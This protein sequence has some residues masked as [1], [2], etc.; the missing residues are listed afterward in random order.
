MSFMKNGDS[1]TFI[2]WPCSSVI[3]SVRWNRL[4]DKGVGYIASALHENSTLKSLRYV[5][6]GTVYIYTL[7][8][9]VYVMQIQYDS[10]CAST[11]RQQLLLG[12][13]CSNIIRAQMAVLHYPL[14]HRIGDNSVE[15]EGWRNVCEMLKRNETLECIGSVVC[16]Q[17]RLVLDI[18][19][20]VMACMYS[21]QSE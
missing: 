6:C 10:L 2:I 18:L 5:S 4:G 17:F 21:T 1:S 3:K 8:I 19:L 20:L 14:F 9:L 12:H 7:L 15:G 11:Q 16:T 13:T